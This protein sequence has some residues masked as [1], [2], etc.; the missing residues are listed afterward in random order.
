MRLMSWGGLLGI[1]AFDL[2]L[3]IIHTPSSN[4][5]CYNIIS[6]L[7]RY[8]VVKFLLLFIIAKFKVQ[9]FNLDIDYP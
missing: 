2:E 1:I 4:K 5:F 7:L 9:I 6:F 3:Y 8:L